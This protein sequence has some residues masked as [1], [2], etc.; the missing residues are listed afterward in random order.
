MVSVCLQSQDFIGLGFNIQGSIRDGIRVSQVHNRGPAIESGKIHAGKVSFFLSFCNASICRIEFILLL[1][2]CQQ[3][4][5]IPF[6]YVV[7]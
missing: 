2:S 4:L 7:I 3:S 1:A 6:L 5:F